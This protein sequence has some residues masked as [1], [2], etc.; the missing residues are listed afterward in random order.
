MRG[1]LRLTRR[2]MLPRSGDRDFQKRALDLIL[3]L[4]AA[5]AT[6]LLLAL[7]AC[8]EIGIPPNMIREDALNEAS[9][10]IVAVAGMSSR[11]Q[12]R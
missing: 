1:I 6:A 11:K 7:I 4:I 12:R 8:D 5:A 10:V 9:I 2:W 3:G